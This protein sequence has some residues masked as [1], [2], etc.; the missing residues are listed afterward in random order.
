MLKAAINV[1]IA[2]VMSIFITSHGDFS[3]FERF[4]MTMMFVI[5]FTLLDIAGSKKE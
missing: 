3:T 4:A 2:T 5:W 1:V